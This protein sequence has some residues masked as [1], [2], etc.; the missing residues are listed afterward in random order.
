MS[1][2]SYTQGLVLIRGAGDLASG[3]AHR[4]RLAGLDVVMTEI[5]QPRAIRRAVSFASAVYEGRA[6]VEGVEARRVE[7]ADEGRHAIAQGQVAVLVDPEAR[8]ALSLRP[9]VLVDAI[10]AKR[11]LS[12]IITAAPLVIGLGPGFTAG[13]DVHVVI[14]TMRGHN[15]GR[16]I[17][18]GGAEPDTGIP[19][20]ILGYTRERVLWSPAE[21]LLRAHRRIGERLEAGTAIAE[22]AG[23]PVVAGVGG[24]LRGL[25]H[26][27]LH[28]RTGE[29]VGDVDP[30]GVVEHC[31]TIS[32]KARA[33][34]GSVLEAVLRA[35]QQR[36]VA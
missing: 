6:V 9:E 29:K 7:T 10:M 23:L 17:T 12:T 33:I 26:D 21:G 19:S 24:V 2:A 28:V 25:L 31:F 34:S 4:L 27:G 22:V 36:S 20:P 15:L 14:E 16:V 11:N 8:I 5:A 30:R 1:P 32:D 18:S 35:R 13:V 3:V